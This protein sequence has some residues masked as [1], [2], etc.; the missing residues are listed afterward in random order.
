MSIPR[1]T[2]W[3]LCA[4]VLLAGTMARAEEAY[5]LYS[6]H[7]IEVVALGFEQYPITVAHN[8]RRLDT[9]LVTLLQ[10]DLGDTRPTTR[11]YAVSPAEVVKLLGLHENLSSQ[12][13]TNGF[14]NT[15]VME[16]SGHEDVR[17]WDAY[18]GYAGSLLVSEGALRHPGWFPKGVA[19]VFAASVVSRDSVTIGSYSKATAYQ[20]Q[21]QPLIP[22]RK[23]LHLHSGDSQ[24]EVPA[25]LY[26]Y[27]AE[28]WYL[29]H[30]IM[31]DKKFNE[32][33]VSYF[34][35]LAKGR[36]EDDAFAASFKTSYEDLDRGIMAALHD[37]RIRTLMIK[38]PDEPVKTQPRRLTPAE[39][40]G[41]LALVAVR[42]P[43]ARDYGMKLVSEALAAEPG[44]EYALRAQAFA[45][46]GAQEYGDALATVNKL[47]G[48]G[49]LSAEDYGD[50]GTII[51]SVAEAIRRKRVS[52][53]DDPAVLEHRAYDDYQHAIDLDSES[54]V[55][56]AA[57]A[58]LLGGSHDTAAVKEF[59]P[60]IEQVFYLH[61]HNAALAYS[62]ARMCGEVGDLDNAFKF[63][64]AWQNNAIDERN[65]DAAATYL[66][67]LKTSIERR[68]LTRPAGQATP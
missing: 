66:A 67:R 17:Y 11:I 45:Q 27:D 56:W 59:L 23:F 1:V 26:L 62:I 22:M 60:K 18:F 6:Y 63:S 5:W 29:A 57:Y 41:R 40:K 3:L 36:G 42:N 52:L 46:V 50:S 39:A 8:V 48:I 31:I 64:V 4:V 33:F 49:S 34:D 65:R 68:N 54:L 16:N 9:A 30:L 13:S 28:C 58:E 14:V 38:V 7:G 43:R 24:L 61:A 44:N 37:G 51:A 10:L 12:F 2:R 47:A 15:V 25:T 32:Q 19:E 21:S 35:L 53:T 20:L 55:Y